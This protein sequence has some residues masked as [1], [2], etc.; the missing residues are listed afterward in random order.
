MTVEDIP[1][2]EDKLA[3]SSN[4]F[5]FFDDKGKGRHP[6]YVSEKGHE[7]VIDLHFW[8]DHYATINNFRRFMTDL[9]RNHTSHWCRRCLGHFDNADV[10]KSHQLYCRGVD[11]TGQFLLNPEA[12]RKVKFENEP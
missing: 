5:R 6:F 12:S 10:L 8:D 11:G 9:S 1:A 3:V 4:V 2:I 7:K